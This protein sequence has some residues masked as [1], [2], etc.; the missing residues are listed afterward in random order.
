MVAAPAEGK[1]R[2]TN[3]NRK[4]EQ[5]RSRKKMIK[6]ERRKRRTRSVLMREIHYDNTLSPERIKPLLET[7]Y[8]AFSSVFQ[9]C[10]SLSNAATTY[11]V[12]RRV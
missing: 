11:F 12:G 5:M 9:G 8:K 2:R 1:R 7:N 4:L 10:F 6:R 3:E